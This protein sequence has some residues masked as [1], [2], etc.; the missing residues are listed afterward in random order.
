M[1]NPIDKALDR[2]AERF[3]LELAGVRAEFRAGLTQTANALRITAARPQV[4][5]PNGLNSNGAGRLVG[6]SLRETSGSAPAV[7]TLYA[8]R[9]GGDPGAVV[10]VVALAAGAST[11]WAP[12]SPGVSFGDG[13]FAVTTG[14]VAGPLYFGAVD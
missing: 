9:D 8:A 10:A 11:L 6:W 4:L 14:A 1:T 12:G 5:N 7:V 13:L 3:A 2:L